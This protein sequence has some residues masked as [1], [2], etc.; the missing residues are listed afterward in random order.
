MRS[1]FIRGTLLALFLGACVA[2]FVG[3]RFGGRDAF[4]PLTPRGRQIEQAIV[5]GRYAE[6]LPLATALSRAY[7][8]EPQ[9]LYW[10]A[11]IHRGL[12]SSSAEIDAWEQ[13]TKLSGAP[14]AACPSLP[15]A[16]AREGR[17]QDALHAYERCARF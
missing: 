16:Y 12:G 1:G 8:Q 17:A 5:S 13:F 4:D 9:V 7:P 10:L 3:P 14:E 15:E 2:R 11:E 6:A